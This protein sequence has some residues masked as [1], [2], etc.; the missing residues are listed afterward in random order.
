MRVVALV[1][2]VLVAATLGCVRRQGTDA[3]VPLRYVTPGVAFEMLRDGG[4]ELPLVDVRTEAEYL[5]GHLAGARG[6]PLDQLEA[7]IATLESHL[8]RSVLLYGGPHGEAEA[9]ALALRAAGFRYPILLR[10]GIEGWRAAG[11]GIVEPAPIASV[12]PDD[13]P[14]S[15]TP[16]SGEVP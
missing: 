12:A 2:V 7:G 16:A 5:A 9:A 14:A 8:R 3:A 15:P 11:F 10:G 1:A 4:A 13:T 6:I